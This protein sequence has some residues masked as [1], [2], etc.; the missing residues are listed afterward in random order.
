MSVGFPIAG[1]DGVGTS[2]SDARKI[3]SSHWA[4]FGVITGAAVS[5]SSSGLTY[6]V[7]S[8]VAVGSRG[9]TYGA[10]EFLVPAGSVT[11]DAVPSSGYRV[12][13]VWAKP[14]DPSQGD[15]SS[16]V[17]LGVTKGVVASASTVAKPALPAGAVELRTFMLPPSATKTSQAQVLGSVNYAIERAGTL[18]TLVDVPLNFD[19]YGDSTVNKWYT[20]QNASFYLPT[21]RKIDLEFS[22][23][24][25]QEQPNGRIDNRGGWYAAFVIDGVKSWG[26]EFEFSNTNRTQYM[27]HRATLEAGQH[28]V[29]ITSTKTW[30]DLRPSFHASPNAWGPQA[31]RR[32]F[33]FDAGVAQ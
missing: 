9:T 17:V 12:D 6:T 33:V 30:G 24:A 28:T 22:V 4:S 14:Q 18:P 26:T 2:V 29:A 3:L 27:R 8:G 21:D 19:G 32:L 10:V 31:G 20:E 23:C 16:D 11:T 15:S 1:T 5:T 7:A 25:S 13:V